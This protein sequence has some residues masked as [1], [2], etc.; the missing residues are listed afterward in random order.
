MNKTSAKADVLAYTAMFPKEYTA[1]GIAFELGRPVPSVRRDIN[2]LRKQG[3][4]AKAAV[5]ATQKGRELYEE[6]FAEEIAYEAALDLPEGMDEDEEFCWKQIPDDKSQPKNLRGLWGL[7]VYKVIQH[8]PRRL[9]LVL[10]SEEPR[11]LHRGDQLFMPP[12]V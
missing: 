2:E 3:L 9:M 6:V 5:A 8:R 4:I 1:A 10:T 11:W 12:V 7:Y